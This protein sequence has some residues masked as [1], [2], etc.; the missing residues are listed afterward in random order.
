MR[1]SDPASAGLTAPATAAPA[2]RSP[3]PGAAAA[4]APAPAPAGGSPDAGSR[5]GH[6]LATAPSRAASTPRLNLELPRQRGGELSRHG[7][8]G[9][10]PV[11][12][13][14]PETKSKLAQEIEK[15][16]RPDCRSAYSAL[17]LVAVV[18]LVR[19]AVAGDGCR[20]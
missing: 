6:D 14:P 20:W 9:L 18:P 2:L 13:R 19:D 10:L 11:L 17:G 15:S 4:V 12:P 16:G 3:S 1:T 7:A 8:P 5:L